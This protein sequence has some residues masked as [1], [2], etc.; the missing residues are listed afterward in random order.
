MTQ[1]W[2]T[3]DSTPA[4][5]ARA[6]ASVVRNLKQQLQDSFDAVFDS[7]TFTPVI[8]GSSVAGVNTYSNQLGV[9][10]RVGD[11]VFIHI[12]VILASK[13]AAMAGEL[14]VTG[15]P[16]TV[17]NSGA[18]GN[19]NLSCTPISLEHQSGYNDWCSEAVANAAYIKIVEAG[20]NVGIFSTQA[21]QVKSNTSALVIS[22]CYQRQP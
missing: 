16:F 11:L 4:D 7:G 20:D 19:Q 1:S 15:L 14:R 18:G 3:Q 13:D 2:F 8:A 21:S 17:K 10:C 9:Y 12:S 22:G 5:H 6:Q